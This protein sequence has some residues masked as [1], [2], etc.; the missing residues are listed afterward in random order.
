M[1][2]GWESAWD[3]EREKFRR[4]ESANTVFLP[5]E[6]QEHERHQALVVLDGVLLELESFLRRWVAF[7]GRGAREIKLDRFLTEARVQTQIYARRLFDYG[8]LFL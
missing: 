1:P 5:S 4:E 2:R 3:R 7:P 6:R 8:E